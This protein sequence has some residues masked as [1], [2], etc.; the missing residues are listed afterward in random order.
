MSKFQFGK[1]VPPSWFWKMF[2]E[3][4]VTFGN[5]SVFNPVREKELDYCEIVCDDEVCCVDFGEWISFEGGELR[6][7]RD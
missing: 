6:V 4:K 7:S 2:E 3:G 5:Y 1:Q